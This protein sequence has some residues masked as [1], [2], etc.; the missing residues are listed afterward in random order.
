MVC[1]AALSSSVP[2]I[3]EWYKARRGTINGLPVLHM[4]INIV[5]H[6]SLQAQ[7]ESFI[8][9]HG[10]QT[11]MNDYNANSSRGPLQ[12]NAV[13]DLF[14]VPF[15]KP[16]FLVLNCISNS[17][18]TPLDRLM[19]TEDAGFGDFSDNG[20]TVTRWRATIDSVQAPLPLIRNARL[21]ANGTFQF[22]FPGQRGRTNQ[23]LCTGDLVN[24]TV[25]TNVTGTNVLFL[26]RDMNT[27]LSNPVRVYR[28]RR[29]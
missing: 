27:T 19:L 12:T 21:E 16:Y 2:N 9:Y 28:V 5:P 29:L 24:W 17:S 3:R 13:H 23:V 26:F 7:C 1:N 4:S 22:Y 20:P 10:L 8:N 15:I 25:L 18:H 14:E 11:V 6:S